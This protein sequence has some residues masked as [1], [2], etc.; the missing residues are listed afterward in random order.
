MRLQ[1]SQSGYA[2]KIATCFPPFFICSLNAENNDSVTEMK[3]ELFIMEMVSNP[4]AV[5][6]YLHYL[7]NQTLYIFMQ[8][9][10]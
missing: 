10:K 3:N 5:K 6:L 1:N 4:F 2:T 8:V 9:R 7:V